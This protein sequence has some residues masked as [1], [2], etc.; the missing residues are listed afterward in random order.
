LS[1]TRGQTI[2]T[3]WVLIPATEAAP[4]WPEVE[5]F[6]AHLDR[7]ALAGTVGCNGISHS[8]LIDAPP[9]APIIDD[10]LFPY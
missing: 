4:R 3:T 7:F 9:P 8:T 6:Y 2:R 5:V 10:G 1:S